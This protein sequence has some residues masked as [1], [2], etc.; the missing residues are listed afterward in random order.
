MDILSATTTDLNPPRHA[1]ESD[2]EDEFNPLPH[3]EKSTEV[4]IKFIGDVKAHHILIV[5][6]GDPGAFWTKG[7]DLGEQIGAITVNGV[8]IGF[9]FNPS[10]AKINVIISESLSKL[11]V[12]AMHPYAQAILDA[13]KP[14]MFVPSSRRLGLRLTDI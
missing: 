5:A 14:T 13:L 11:P 2:D 8:H 6:Q 1:I 3:D 7:A 10:W 4:G 12:W 9:L